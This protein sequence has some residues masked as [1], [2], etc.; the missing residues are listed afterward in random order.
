MRSV[1]RTL[2]PLLLVAMV[3]AALSIAALS[4]DPCTNDWRRCE[5]QCLEPYCPVPSFCPCLEQ[6]WYAYKWCLAGR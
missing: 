2:I 5:E 1:P 3:I 4:V 6:C